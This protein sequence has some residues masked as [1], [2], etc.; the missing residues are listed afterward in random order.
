MICVILFG[1]KMKRIGFQY[2]FLAIL[3]IVFWAPWISAANT[4]GTFSATTTTSSEPVWAPNLTLPKD[5]SIFLC[6]PDSICYDVKGSDPDGN[7][8]LL[9]TLV[10]GPI[11]FSPK[12]FPTN[13]FVQP[14][15]FFPQTSGTYRFIWKVTDHT[16]QSAIDTITFTIRINRPPHIDDQFYAGT[17]C[18]GDTTRVLPVVATDPDG[19]G[20]Y[21]AL[22]SGSGSINGSTGELT[23]YTT[24]AGVKQFIVGVFDGCSS[25]TAIIEDTVGISL[26]PYLTTND[27]VLY[28]CDTGA[29]TLTV[30]A[31]DPEGGSVQIAQAEGPGDFVMTTDTSGQTTFV[32]ARL[33]SARYVFVYCLSDDCLAAKNARLRVPICVLDTVIVTVH[34]NRPPM[35][36]CPAE[37]VFSGCSVQSAC[38]TVNA[39]DPDGDAVNLRLLSGN[40]TLT[41]DL[42]CIS[43]QEPADF[44]IV[45]EAVDECGAADTCV[46]HV[47]INPNH[48][49]VVTSAADFAIALCKPE[50][51]CFHVLVDDIDF[52]IASVT[53]SFG[54]YDRQTNRVCFM[55]DSSGRYTIITTAADSCGATGLDTTVVTVTLNQPPVVHLGVDTTINLC[56]PEEICLPVLVEDAN[57]KSVFTSVGQIR[58]NKICFT[59]EGSGTFAII[60]TATDDCNVIVADTQ[61]LRV[62]IGRPALLIC[63][64]EYD[65]FVCS[66]DTTATFCFSP[67]DPNDTSAVTL[68]VLTGNAVVDGRRIC[69]SANQSADFVVRVEA[70]GI[71]GKPDTCETLVRMRIN[72]PPRV[73]TAPDFNIFLCRPEPICF[74]AYVDDPDFNI[75][76]VHANYGTYDKPSNRICFNADTAGVYRIIVTATD[77][78]GATARDT[79]VVTVGMNKPPVVKL[80]NDTSFSFCEPAQVCLPVTITDA[81]LKLVIP[82]IGT[83]DPQTHRICFTPETNGRYTIVVLAE[84]SCGYRGGDSIN[85]S[86]RTGHKPTVTVPDTS[87]YVC[88]PRQICLPVSVSDQ[89]G[90]IK[91]VTVNRGKYSD[92]S[93]CFV[94][95][96]AGTYPVIVTVTDS[97][98]NIVS[99][100]GIVTVRTDQNVQLTCPRD[101]TIFL[102]TP[103]TLCFPVGGI[104]DD[105]TVKVF[106]TN[107]RWNNQTKSVCFYSDC[108]LQNSIK[109]EVTTAC[110]NKFTCAFTVAVQTNSAPIVAVPRDTT[111]FACSPGGKICMPV[112][113]NDIDRN[114]MSITSSFGTYDAYRQILCFN[115][116]TAGVYTAVITAKDSCGLTGTATT[117]IHVKF[118]SAPTVDFIVPDWIPTVCGSQTIQFCAGVIAEDIDSNI[119]SITAVG[120]KYESGSV[121]LS[122]SDSGLYCAVITVTDVCGAS[123]TDSFCVRAERRDSVEVHCGGEPQDPENF[124]K[125]DSISVPVYITGNPTQIITNIGEYRDGRI[126]LPKDTTKEFNY[127][128]LTVIAVGPCNTDTCSFNFVVQWLPSTEIVCPRDTTILLCQPGVLSFPIGVTGDILKWTVTP[129][130]Y[131]EGNTLKLP[132]SGSGAYPII[133]IAD[134]MCG[135]DTCSFTVKTILNTPPVV[136]SRDTTLL[137]CK[138]QPVCLPIHVTDIDGNI[139]SITTSLGQILTAGGGRT[140]TDKNNARADYIVGGE[141][142]GTFSPSRLGTD[143]S[144]QVCFTPDRFGDYKIIVTATDACASTVDT[145]VVTVNSDGS[146]AVV[147]PTVE[148]TTLCKPDTLCIPITI[149]GNGFVVTTSFGK[150]ENGHLCFPADTGGLYSIRVIGTAVCNADTCDLK[151]PVTM[152]EPV[153]V[154]CRGVDTTVFVCKP[155]QTVSIPVTITGPYTNVSVSPQNATIVN[156]NIVLPITEAGPI[157]IR[158]I[159]SNACYSDSC[160]FT[161]NA[162]VNRPPVV[163]VDPLHTFQLC[164]L[165]KVCIKFHATDPDYNIVE[166]RS[167]LG[168]I[169]DSIL[170]FT[171]ESQGDFPITIKAIDACGDTTTATTTVRIVKVDYPQIA[172]PKDT[173]AVTANLPD[174][175][176]MNLAIFP[177]DANVQVLPNGR[178]DFAT[179]QLVVYVEAPGTNT[180]KVLASTLCGTDSC[181]VVIKSE[182]FIPAHVECLASVDT[183]LCLTS[184]TT[185]CLPVTITGTAVNVVVKP[186]GTYAD[187]QVCVPITQAGTIDL[188]IIAS[189]DQ[190]ADT[191]ATRITVRDGRPPVVQLPADTSLFLCQVEGVCLPITI[192]GTDFG[193]A[194]VQ[195]AGGRF[196]AGEQPSV[197]FDAVRDG[198]FTIIVTATDSCGHSAVDTL[199]VTVKINKLPKIILFTQIIKELCAP[200]RACMPIIIE[201]DNLASVVTNGEYDAEHH[202]LCVNADTSGVYI[203]TVTATDSC[204]MT[205]EQSSTLSVKINRAPIIAGLR[206]TTIYLCKPQYVCLPVSISDPDGEQ[207]T[208]V[209]S[210]GTYDNGSICFAPYDSGSFQII[211]TATDSCGATAVDTATVHVR[212]D[213]G[214]VLQCPRDTTIFQCQPQMRCFPVGGIPE[215]ATVRVQGTNVTWNAQTKSVCFFSDCCLENKITVYVTTQCG[216]YSCSFTVKVQTNSAPIVVLPRD[217]AY[218]A[219]TFGQI[220]LPVAINDIDKNVASVTAVG[221]AYDAYRQI[222][223]LTPQGPG[224]YPIIVTATDTCG[225]IDVDTTVITLLDNHPPVITFSPTDTLF[226]QCS[227][228]EI[229]I[230]VSIF[231]PD[232]NIVSIGVDGGTYKPTRGEICIMPTG[233]GR[234]C[235]SISAVDKCGARDTKSICVTVLDGDRTDILC[236]NPRPTDTLCAA[237]QVCLPV[238]VIGTGYTVLTSFGV[239]SEGQLCF[240]ADTSGVYT[241]KVVAKTQCNADTCTITQAVKILEKVDI[242]C[243][244]NQ[245]IFLCEPDTLCYDFTKSAS[246]TH[247][248]V[249]AP[250]YVSGTQ[251]C[252]PV[253]QQGSYPI[254]VIATG[255]CGADTCVFTVNATF[256]SPPRVNAGKDTT[257]TECSF[258]QVC[259]PVEVIDLNN[260]A[261]QVTTSLGIIS[262]KTLCFTPTGYGTFEIII[263]AT[264]SCGAIGKDTVK[265]TYNQGLSAKITCP[266]GSQFASLCKPDSVYVIVPITPPTAKV[267]ILPSGSYNPATGKVAIWVTSAGTKHIKV[268]AEAQCTNDS[269]EFDLQVTF[270]EAP[271]VTCHPTIDTLMCLT[272]DHQLCFPLTVTGTGVTVT[273][274]P[275]G[276]Y[277][278][279]V[280]CIPVTAAGKYDTRIIATGVCGADSCTVPITVRSNQ[281]P[282]LHLPVDITIQRCPQDT[283]TVCI[284]GFSA[285]DPENPVTLTMVCGIGS[286]TAVR[287]DSGSICFKPTDLKRYEFCF[288][289]TDGCNTVTDTF[290]VTFTPKPDC[291]VCLKVSV[292]GGK[293]TPVGL[294]KQVAIN[295]QSNE[296]IGGFDLLIAYDAS[297][298]SYQ[299]ATITNSD[300]TGWEYFTWKIGGAGCGS[301]CPSGVVRLVGIADINNGGNHPPDSSLHPNGVLAYLDFLVKNDQTLGGQFV[302]ISFVWY[303]CSDNSFSNPSGTLLLV[304]RRIY[305]AD[306]VVIWDETDDAHYPEASRTFGMGAPDSCLNQGGK[307]PP[308]RCIDFINGGV[309]IIEADSIDARGDVNLN[310]LAYE[311]A[312]AVVFTNYFIKG[313]AAFTISVAGQIA[314]TDINGD[315]LTLTVSDL[316]LLIRIIVGDATKLPKLNPYS[317][318]AVVESATADG[319]IR[320]IT[321]TVDNI[322]AAYFVYDLDPSMQVG[323][324]E[325]GPDASGMDLLTSVEKNQLRVLVYNIGHNRIESGKRELLQIAVTGSGAVKL[326]HVELVDYQGRAYATRIGRIGLPDEYVLNQNYPNPFNPSTVISFSLPQSSSWTLSIYNVTGALVREFTGDSEAGGIDVAWDGHGQSGTQAASGIYLYKL[327]AGSF[328]DTKKMILLK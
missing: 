36:T 43:L 322:G 270:N 315:G 145:V 172:C 105:A 93:V 95:Y 151:I 234:Y 66:T 164:Q 78:C 108:C 176:R 101:T 109:V 292:D 142:G 58:D 37:K 309:C 174:S 284:A 245:T 216:T 181:S 119:A 303:D 153:D 224:V 11:S 61:V 134:G 111:I 125:Q 107:V 2:L 99:D 289:A 135:D 161:V 115:T 280:V 325:A 247:V 17:L 71:C 197:C 39:T 67:L 173:L 79:T 148:P 30:S 146:V 60:V 291:D 203:L 244:G 225:L 268:K 86:V 189:N 88:Y 62:N 290:A 199:N 169:N 7:D 89:D 152:Y 9:L 162:I 262:G 188:Q 231:D 5:T 237:G 215:G 32:P 139:V 301:A 272:K 177:P 295:V 211:V 141:E 299:T 158:V 318:V 129:P 286:Y 130:A 206:D 52:N 192:A 81:N 97:C 243:P 293:C 114:V 187:G 84:D 248:S 8:T 249:S 328:T 42:V 312:D 147:C 179:R 77:T 223:C 207:L 90:D 307:T 324:I 308:V 321:E 269:C 217:T 221:G 87:I 22:L 267:T 57:L 113:V 48:A 302:P 4:P 120:G 313:L 70:T 300:I 281:A 201:D 208:I 310:G 258:K 235:V 13:S 274:K 143:T 279:G 178:Y 210:R 1:G 20:L 219:C 68:R 160:M 26:P 156:G 83:Y 38:W 92:G 316:A 232:G 254:T 104:P 266:S 69:V 168:V 6:A 56:Q 144:V 35:L 251:V 264:D 282:T 298:L 204:G 44:D 40:A 51:V 124:C 72:Q 222:V 19:D 150:Y 31:H 193:I 50:Q 170:C 314:A 49:P 220:C 327:R 323:R 116:D 47:T 136:E 227:P 27:T 103:D 296:A 85:V 287:A 82:S 94:P 273:V 126:Y 196:V 163:T 317:E 131:M 41:D 64:S 53:P 18:A 3:V 133:L 236:P 277:S 55:A 175:V 238:R 23:Y 29:I 283:Q 16:N 75:V 276:T 278:A 259:L 33:D 182:Q 241:I 263:T 250:A 180:F 288:Q 320:V 157:P 261:A 194:D 198:I 117:R 213:Q 100:T 252:L 138:L 137:L 12:V 226:K 155:G 214:L 326:S 106:G 253:L 65:Y 195:V 297:A 110:G 149:T 256:N 271:K 319:L 102:C 28:V 242:A 165:E 140:T 166:L 306:K 54:T 167:S 311:I 218:I 74:A 15:C 257:L 10:S 228:T 184:P 98:G 229:C 185:L 123:V 73:E 128:D 63:E 275:S 45:I 24:S 132:V 25:D 265:V 191:C 205:T 233:P 200:G 46:T 76:D 209:T 118:N 190:S 59:P 202:Q 246:V 121:C 112:A 91:S 304:D 171:P 260:N 159:A 14:V 255:K 122:I 294:R 285:K 183:L 230:P 305:N 240:N 34:L 239:W 154:V 96:S 127:F 186:V 212:T 21:F 80:G